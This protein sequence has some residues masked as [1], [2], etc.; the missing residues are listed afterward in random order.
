[1]SPPPQPWSVPPCAALSQE[2]RSCS[3]NETSFLVAIWYAPSNEPV[4]EKAQ[5]EPHWPW[6]LIGVTAP[7]A[8]QSTASSPTV[9]SSTMFFGRRRCGLLAMPD[10]YSSLNSGQ[11]RSENSL[12]PSSKV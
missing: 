12:W 8:D 4:V 1:M 2:T 6:F 7:L 11:V 10:T 3:E 9:G 5:Q